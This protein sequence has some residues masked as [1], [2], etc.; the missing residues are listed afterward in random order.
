M[1]TSTLSPLL[2]HLS[3][4]LT[5]SLSVMSLLVLPSMVGA[6][7]E[8]TPLTEAQAGFSASLNFMGGA[9]VAILMSL[10]IHHISLRKAALFGFALALITDIGC[11]F[12]NQDTLAFMLLRT[13]NGMGSTGAT[14][15]A[16]V[17]T[18]ARFDESQKG[19]GWLMTF[20]FGISALGLYV[21]ADV[22]ERLGMGGMF[23]LLAGLNAAGFL[24]SLLL[25]R[26]TLTVQEPAFIEAKILLKP[27]A[28]I[29]IV[30]LGLYEAANTSQFT[31]TER[32]G[33]S[34]NLASDDIGW[35]MAMGS[36]VGI[37]GAY[38]TVVLGDRFGNR[39]PLLGGLV[40]SAMA[41][42]LMLNADDLV[43]YTLASFLLGGSWA[44]T[45]PYYQ[46]LQPEID[47]AGSVVAAGSFASTIGNAAGP[48]IAST[49]LLFGGYPH[50]FL[51]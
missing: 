50:I 40:I 30:G 39:G 47:P 38:A 35:V 11:S 48:G 8:A 42:A 45:F 18:I 22:M 36:L 33:T 24:L 5:G 27:V 31:F 49:I 6:I 46:S 1:K 21:M 51:L 14:Y 2:R 41:M 25:D 23:L 32:L 7:S 12:Y 3:L 10:R 13:L 20:Q 44:F 29:S 43:S 34:L 19:Y 37:V 26:A 28:L 4:A 17:A 9:L 15:T 16:I